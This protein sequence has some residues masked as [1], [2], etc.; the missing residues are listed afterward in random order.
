M[1]ANLEL[2]GALLTMTIYLGFTQFIT[3]SVTTYVTMMTAYEKLDTTKF[4]SLANMTKGYGMLAIFG[5]AFVTQVLNTFGIAS[6]INTMVWDYGVTGVGTL[7]AIVY[8]V[9]IF[10]AYSK[11][12]TGMMDAAKRTAALVAASQLEWEFAG[13][14]AAISMVWVAYGQNLTLWRAAATM[15][16]K[17]SMKTEEVEED[18]ELIVI[19]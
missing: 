9:F 14:M 15:A 10:M 6:S 19:F 8:G 5:V 7:L 17:E 12:R 16:E 3:N 4:W 1:Q 11:C 2:M 13:F 18:V